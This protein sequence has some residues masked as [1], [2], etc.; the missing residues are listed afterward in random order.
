MVDR[1]ILILKFYKMKKRYIQILIFLSFAILFSTTRVS[2]QEAEKKKITIES[3]V[4]DDKGNPVKGAIIYGNEGAIVAKSDA[5][6]KFTI[7]VPNQTDLLIESDGYDPLVLKAGEY[8]YLKEFSLTTSKLFYGEKDVVN[9]AFGKK[10]RGDIVNA[11]SALDAREISKYD[12]SQSIADA[13]LGQVPG[14]LGSNNIYALGNSTQ[15]SSTLTIVDGLPRDISTI[16]MSEVE[17]ITFLKDLNSAILYGSAAVNGVILI[18]TK[19]GQA[20]KKEMKVMGYYGVSKPAALPKYLSSA[21]FMPLYNEARVNDGLTALYTQTDIDNYTSGNKYRYPSVDYY[22]SE[23]LKSVRPFSS[24]VTELSGG[25]DIALYYANIGWDQ[26]GNILNF[27]QGAESHQNRFNVRGNVDLKINS[28][29]KSSIDVVGVFNNTGGPAGTNY[30]TTAALN[31]P[32]LF[33][34]LLPMNLMNPNIALLKNRKNDVGGMYLLG[35][36]T[37]Y[38]TN[39][40]ANGYS[41]GDNV[42]VQRTFSL[43]NRIDF[44][45]SRIVKGLAFRTNVSFDLYARYDQ[46]ITNT[47]SVYNPTWSATT[48]SITALTQYASDARPGTQNVSNGYYERK[49]GFYGMFDYDRTFAGDHKLGGSLLFFGNKYNYQGNF[50]QNKNVNLGLRLNYSYK[51]KYMVDFSSAYV[52]SIKLSKENRRVLSPSL[53]LA[54]VISSEDFLSSVSAIDYLKLKAS[55]SLMNSDAGIDGF[56]YWQ[57]VYVAS[58]SYSWNEGGQYNQGTAS[59]YGGNSG[60]TWEKRKELNLGLEGLFFDR[61]LSLEANLFTTQYYNQITRPTSK[62]PSFYT[63]FLPYENFDNIAYR[64]AELGIS[65]NKSIGDLSFVVGTNMMYATSEV[66]KK[67]EL[68]AFAYQ[69]RKGKPFD[70]RFGLVSNGFFRDAADI[71]GSPLQAFGTVKPGDIKYVDQNNDGVIDSNDE[72]QIGRSQAPFSYGLNLKIIYKNFTLFTRGTG[73]IGAD[74]MVSNN[75]YWVDGTDKY[76]AFI[77]NRWTP[78]TASTATFPRLSSLANSNDFRNST[79]WQFKDNYFTLDALQLT[80]NMPDAAAKMVGM[81]NLSFYVSGSYLFTISKHKDIRELSIGNEPYYRS[82]SIGVK[83]VF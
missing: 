37:S 62:Y 53:G 76:S 52:N 23:Y 68:Y 73:R 55:T 28:W 66:M 32:N 9:I 6:G 63:N 44:D 54:W 67:D 30:F 25:N 27:G 24:V 38:L 10:K 50:Q 12:N 59:S 40:I 4:K 81:K 71:A 60:L 77:M 17:Q 47:Y 57:N 58:G 19:R 36:T 83:T 61:L 26:T 48:D 18:T 13:I 79:F 22:S 7:S 72:I 11:V 3:V 42:N 20:H 21:E 1:K 74:G 35:G 39:P 65:V 45:L 78:A 15:L 82:Y 69:Y 41:G 8:E 75:Y 49:F 80:Y 51:E 16:K 34:P 64:G 46:G 2:A 33:S 31:K 43:N 70:A 5:S 14:L 56:Y 29:V